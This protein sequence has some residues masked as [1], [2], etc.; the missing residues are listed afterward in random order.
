MGSYKKHWP[1]KRGFDRF[2]GFSMGGG[3]YFYPL[4]PGRQTTLDD[5]PA[6]VN[7]ETF[8]STDAINDYAVRFIDE[9]ESEFHFFLYI[10]HIAPHFPLQAHQYDVEKYREKYIKGFQVLRKRRFEKIK[11]IGILPED[12][13]L[14][15]PDETVKQWEPLSEQKKEEYDHR[16]AV[17]AAQIECMDRGLGRMFDALKR[18]Q[19]MGNTLIVFFS[20]NSNSKE[21]PFIRLK[22]NGKEIKPLAGKSMAPLLKG[23]KREPHEVLFWE[24]EGIMVSEKENG[25]WCNRI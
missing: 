7:E 23:K 20:D 9:H 13:K 24:H 6:E 1:L 4:R 18:D 19:N 15:E 12:A 22:Y 10:A 21:D 16:M 5:Q 11:Q 25:N 8:Y 2:F 14:S 3:V 17:Y